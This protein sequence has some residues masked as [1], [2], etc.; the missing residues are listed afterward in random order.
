MAIVTGTNFSDWLDVADGATSGND[1]LR[2]LGGNDSLLGGFG[3]D[4]L[5]GGNDVDTAVYLDSTVGVIVSLGSAGADGHGSGGT[6]Q[7]DVLRNIENITGSTSTDLLIGNDGSNLLSGL[8]GAD[9]LKGGGGVDTLEGG[10]D[11][12]MLK[13]GGG[14]DVLNGGIGIDTA[15]YN[16]SAVGVSVNLF[17]NRGVFGDAA[18]DTFI[19]IENVSG[20]DFRDVIVGDVNANVLRGQDGDDDLYG[21]TGADTLWGGLGNDRLDGG[22]GVDTMRGEA[23]NDSYYVNTSADMVIEAAGEGSDSVQ[24]YA[25]YSLAAGSEIESLRPAD[26]LGTAAIDLVGN[27]FGQSITGNNGQNTIVGGGGQDFLSGWGG[28]DVFVWT[29]TAETGVGGAEADVIVDFD[30]ASGDLMAFNPIDAN[31]TIAGDQAFVFI[32]TAEFTAAGQI[33]YFTT[34]DD[35]TYI[36]LNT[37]GDLVQ[38]ATIHLFGAF[39]VDASWFVL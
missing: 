16:E 38:E 17:E 27:E 6:A 37:D 10:S 26:P 32:G 36:L 31:E 22:A 20:S 21:L 3:A 35:E 13:G 33:R 14:A 19:S 25:T 29:S 23:G 9:T 24:T 11:D 12:D 15:A 4:L 5:D 2:G 1:E 34:A 18:G 39:T 28:G 30:R 8:N 7:G